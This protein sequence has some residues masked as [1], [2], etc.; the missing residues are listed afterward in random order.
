V[1][2]ETRTPLPTPVLPNTGTQ[3]RRLLNRVGIMR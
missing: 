1:L 3:L 2:C